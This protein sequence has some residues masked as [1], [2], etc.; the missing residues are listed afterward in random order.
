MEFV[1]EESDEEFLNNHLVQPN[2]PM[3]ESDD[4]ISSESSD[5]SDYETADEETIA[6]QLNP[7]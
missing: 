1:G 3:E 7:E 6:K 2:D 5:D 4:G